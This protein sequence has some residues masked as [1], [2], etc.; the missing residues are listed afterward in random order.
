MAA[1]YDGS[2]S[3]RNLSEKPWHRSLDELLSHVED[4]AW[5]YLSQRRLS[6]YSADQR[7]TM[8]YDISMSYLTHMERINQ[9]ALHSTTGTLVRNFDIVEWER[10]ADDFTAWY[11]ELE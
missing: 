6:R 1:A 3:G 5:D 2:S 11:D 10:L 8:I 9:I 7:D 4:V